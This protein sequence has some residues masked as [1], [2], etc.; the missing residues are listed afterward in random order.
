MKE[1]SRLFDDHI[2][3]ETLKSYLKQE[4]TPNERV[5]NLHI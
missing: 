5:L 4:N 1:N 2:S 3:V